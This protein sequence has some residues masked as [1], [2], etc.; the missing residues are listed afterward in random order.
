MEIKAIYILLLIAFAFI[1]AVAAIP[2]IIKVILGKKIFDTPG[3][4]KI[5]KTCTPSMGGIGV[6]MS[7]IIVA[8]L[9]IHESPNFNSH[10]YYSALII[11]FFTGLRDDLLPVRGLYKFI[12]QIIA[13]A[14]VSG[15]ANIRLTSLYSLSFLYADALPEWLS[16]FITIFTIVAFTNAYNLIDGI[17]GLA[18]SIAIL[19]LGVLTIWFGINHFWEFAFLCGIMLGAILGFLYYNWTPAKIFMGDTGS[20]II[21]FFCVTMLIKFMSLNEQSTYMIEGSFTFFISMFVY[22]AF[23]IIRVF[24][25]RLKRKRSPFSPDKLHIHLL[26]KRIGLEHNQITCVIFSLSLICVLLFFVMN[27]FKVHELAIFLIISCYCIG[28]NIFLSKKVNEFKKKKELYDMKKVLKNNFNA[29]SSLKKI[30]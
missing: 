29:K 24:Y 16:F 3:G 11:L 19:I 2:Q 15:F 14:I 12:I 1:V 17:D 22:P 27:H 6:F 23:D 30:R 8:M 10:Y 13:A 18:A 25:I 21:G 20:L 28:L 5:H 26:L 7:F 9:T 4:R